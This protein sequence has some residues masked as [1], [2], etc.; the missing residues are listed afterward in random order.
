M[1][2]QLVHKET[3][4]PILRL[5]AAQ[6]AAHAEQEKKEKL[7]KKIEEYYDIVKQTSVLNHKEQI[8]RIELLE[9]GIVVDTITAVTT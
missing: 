8:L 2:Q 7:I 9:E 6:K 5:S 1:A 4:W 3:W